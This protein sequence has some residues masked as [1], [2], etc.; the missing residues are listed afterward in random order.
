MFSII[1]NVQCSFQR[2]KELERRQ[3]L[4]Y[5][6]LPRELKIFRW[7]AERGKIEDAVAF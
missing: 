3:S 5:F 6:Y 7:R 4:L 2:I 1:D